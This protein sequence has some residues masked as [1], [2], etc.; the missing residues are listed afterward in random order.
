MLLHEKIASGKFVIVGEFEPPKGADFSSLLTNANHVRGRVDALVVPEMANAVMKASSLGGSAY[1]Q[2]HGFET[3]F[4][5]SCRDRNRLALQADI[6]AAAA[7][8]IPNIMAVTGED[9]TFGDHH[10][11]RAVYDLNLLQLLEVLQGLQQGK[12]MAGIELRGSPQFFV[13]TTFNAGATGGALDVELAELNKKIDLGI[14]FIITSPVFEVSRL[15][16]IA[17]RI[18]TS[19][20]AVI[21][22]VMILKSAGMARY[23]DRNIRNISIP[24]HIIQSIQ[25]AAD[26][27][28]QCMKIAGETITSLK[29]AG[30]GG[31]L[32]STIGWEDKL[33][34]V[35]D[36]AR[37]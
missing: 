1:L 35:L 7:L 36:E 10:Q 19:R 11:A 24:P 23:I 13:G 6:L 25:K 3:V 34:L 2:S 26:K 37:I 30:M 32:I 22:T 12:D 16:Q 18:D 27:A 29:E 5:I 28:R 33:P 17:K 4:Q 31:V 14:Q 9:I 20:V 8:G 21:P 15:Q